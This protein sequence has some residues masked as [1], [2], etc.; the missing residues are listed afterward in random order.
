MTGA[1]SIKLPMTHSFSLVLVC[2]LYDTTFTSM[3]ILQVL[4]VRV[5]PKVQHYLLDIYY[6]VHILKQVCFGSTRYGC[7]QLW[8]LCFGPGGS[9][10]SYYYCCCCGPFHN[11][12]ETHEECCARRESNESLRCMIEKPCKGIGCNCKAWSS[13]RMWDGVAFSDGVSLPEHK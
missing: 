1:L 6:F 2:V 3:R 8:H 7:I 5:V 4:H 13:V 9:L 10:F 12:V 11:I